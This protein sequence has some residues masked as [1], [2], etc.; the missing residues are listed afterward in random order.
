MVV[1]VVGEGQA[2]HI[3]Y[4]R[5]GI[6]LPPGATSSSVMGADL[7]AVLGLIAD[8]Q[9]DDKLVSERIVMR[10]SRTIAPKTDTAVLL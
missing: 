10:N 8:T 6:H 1:M 5:Q 3:H 7:R 9:S 2:L 4:R